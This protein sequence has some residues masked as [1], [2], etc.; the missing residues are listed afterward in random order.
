MAVQLFGRSGLDMIPMLNKGADGIADLEAK[1]AAYGLT[2]TK[3]DQ[4]ALAKFRASQRDLSLATEGVKTS[5][6]KSLF[7][8][9]TEA[10]TALVGLLPPLQQALTP[11]C[12]PWATSP[13][14]HPQTDREHARRGEGEGTRGRHPQHCRRRG[15]QL[16]EDCGDGR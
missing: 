9:L 16:A 7:P 8:V 11:R 5:F 4:D 2:L 14:G 3:T 13:S 10:N 6:G 12:N 15:T 1:T